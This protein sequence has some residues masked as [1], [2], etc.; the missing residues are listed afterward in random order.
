VTA[1]TLPA[2]DADLNLLLEW[3][4]RRTAGQ[5]AAIIA[6]SLAFHLVLFSI[7]IQ[8]PSFVVPSEPERRIIV[9]R[10]KLY[11][12]PD[13]LTQKAPNRNKVTQNIDLA[14]LLASQAAQ[15]HRPSPEASAKRFELPK[16]I[17]PKQMAKAAPQILPEAPNV[18]VNQAPSPLPPGAI[19][20]IGAPAP[21][22][23]TPSQSPFQSVG[24][25][26]PP[27]P[28]PAITPPRATVQEPMKG[29]VQ[30][31]NSTQIVISDD[32]MSEPSPLTPGATKE[33]GA[34]HAAVELQSDPR[35]ADLKPYLTRILAIV[36]A[37]W[38]RVI[39]ES[40]RMGTLRGRTVMEF[41]I[42]K[43][44]SI[45]KLVT[46]QSS[47]SEPLDRAAAAGLSMSNPLP[48]LPADF[49]GFQVRLAFTFSY[50]LPAQ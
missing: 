15:A 4:P 44:G 18:A 10:T 25:E 38:R 33:P 8:L 16:Q 2:T 11:L 3:P 21:P 49:K 12:P 42:N 9:K 14:S 36:R 45:P 1:A 17:A 22:P 27:N 32:S 31:G 28:H 40:A 5:W 7:A 24:T 50:N 43:D 46:A 47:G 26:A 30:S 23:P 13:V 37:N 39:P 29:V 34:E 20:G 41:I 6:G 35:G 19:S 48:A